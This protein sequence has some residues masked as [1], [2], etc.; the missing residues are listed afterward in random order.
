[1]EARR[2]EGWEVLITWGAE[3]RSTYTCNKPR[4]V[5]DRRAALAPGGRLP[6]E[7]LEVPGTARI[8]R[9]NW[10]CKGVW[11]HSGL[12]PTVASGSHGTRGV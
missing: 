11:T 9:N 6:A 2:E 1:M 10:P 4:R 12:A 3:L 5:H 8:A 7:T